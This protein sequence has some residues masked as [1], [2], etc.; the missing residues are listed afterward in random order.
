MRCWRSARSLGLGLLLALW[1]AHG[2]ASG[3][4]PLRASLTQNEDG[5]ALSAQ[6]AVN[7]G[8]HLQEAVS[9]GVEL[10]FNLEFELNRERW[11]WLD[12][13]VV[14]ITVSYRLSYNALTRQYRLTVGGLHQNF[15]SFDEALQVLGH[16]A[17]LPVADRSLLKPGQ[18]Y[19][20]ALR[21]SLDKSQLPKP[22]QVDAIANSDWNVEAKVLRWQYT[23]PGGDK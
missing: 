16:V 6:F 12:E 9:R 14:G 19:R 17:A 15:D 18:T 1:S 13:H 3:I 23:V 7:L 11:Y 8:A 2:L 20:A 22:F 21:L 10:T 5:Y 4:E